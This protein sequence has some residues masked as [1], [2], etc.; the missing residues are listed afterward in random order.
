MKGGRERREGRGQRARGREREVKSPPC[1]PANG[2][3]EGE[4]AGGGVERVDGRRG[5]PTPVCIMPLPAQVRRVSCFTI[6]PID[7][8][9]GKIL[10]QRRRRARGWNVGERRKS[11]V[12]S[13]CSAYVRIRTCALIAER[14]VASPRIMQ[15][16]ARKF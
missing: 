5:G 4:M 8:N 15:Q 14:A 12:V 3:G 2:G 11:T 10:F 16:P 9:P 6:S 1:D 13:R 7:N